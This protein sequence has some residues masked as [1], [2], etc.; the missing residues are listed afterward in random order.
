LPKLR[1]NRRRDREVLKELQ[2]GGWSVLEV[3]ECEVRSGEG[4]AEKLRAFVEES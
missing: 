4:L 1:R 2:S 3:W